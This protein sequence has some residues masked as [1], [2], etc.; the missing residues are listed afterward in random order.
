MNATGSS[1][2]INHAGT[3]DVTDQIDNFA[4][5]ESMI[6]TITAPTLL[7]SQYHISILSIDFTGVGS[8]AGA[9]A[10]LVSIDGGGNIK[11]E[12]G[13]SGFNGTFD[14][15]TLTGNSLEVSSTITFTAENAIGLGGITFAFVQNNT[16]E[17]SVLGL[18][19]MG[20]GLINLTRRK[21]NA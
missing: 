13:V 16:P 18:Y 20:A 12:T 2:G 8:A 19:A 15:W 5:F 4:G 7:S 1:L 3:G 14:I 10:A 9:D 11:L 21:I 17:P 6:F